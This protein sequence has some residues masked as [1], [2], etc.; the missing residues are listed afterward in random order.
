MNPTVKQATKVCYEMLP[1]QPLLHLIFELSQRRRTNACVPLSHTKTYQFLSSTL[2]KKHL[3]ESCPHFTF[4]LAS[5]IFWCFSLA[6]PRSSAWWAAWT[7]SSCWRKASSTQ[8]NFSSAALRNRPTQTWQVR[9][10]WYFGCSPNAAL[11]KIH[12]CV[13]D[14]EGPQV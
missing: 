10:E 6:S 2:E 4:W 1:L 5:S 7:D 3:W 9:K 13:F 14:G 8:C 11:G 12:V